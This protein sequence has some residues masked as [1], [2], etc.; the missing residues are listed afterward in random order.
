MQSNQ[1]NYE[2]VRRG[3]DFESARRLARLAAEAERFG[4]G[5]GVSLTTPASNAKLAQDPAECKSALK[6]EF[7][8]AGLKV[9]PT[10]TR[11]DPEHHTVLL[12]KPVTLQIA[13]AFNDI[14]KRTRS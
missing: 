12:P 9:V 1:S 2:L 4:F 7:K 11:N 5:H 6:S 14:L 10:P 3:R 13:K 8:S